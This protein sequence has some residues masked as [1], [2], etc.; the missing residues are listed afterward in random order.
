MSIRPPNFFIPGAQ[1]AGTTYLCSQLAKHPDVFITKPK[2]PM[3]FNS[4]KY[5]DANYSWYKEQYFQAAKDERWVGDGSTL[6]FQTPKALE[7][8]HKKLGGDVRF[9]VCMRHPLQKA[10]SLYLHNYRRGR[11]TGRERLDEIGDGPFRI[12]ALSF[13]AEHIRNLL[14]YFKNTNLLFLKYDELEENPDQFVAKA[15]E[16]LGIVPVER[17]SKNKINKGFEL[18]FSCGAIQPEDRSFTVGPGQ[19]KPSFTLDELERLQAA[20]NHDVKEAQELTKMNLSNW[21]ALPKFRGY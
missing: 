19:V 10:L 9:I 6:Y 1:K 11:L 8:I 18:A 21:L 5:T 13:Y 7:R 2:E 3:F 14:K 17:I 4:R 12:T 15:C 16:F 20:F